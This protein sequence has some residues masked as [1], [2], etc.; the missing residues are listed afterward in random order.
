MKYPALC[1]A[2]LTALLAPGLAMAQAQVQSQIQAPDQPQSQPQPQAPDNEPVIRCLLQQVLSTLTCKPL[3]EYHFV[4]K[5]D[6]V[7]VYNTYF[8]AHFTEFYC[9]I[10]DKDVT[11]TSRAWLGKMASARLDYESVPG[12][13]SAKVNSPP[14][15]CHVSDTVQCCGAQ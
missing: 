15:E 1:L 6:D 12:C 9:Q 5:R 11:I 2:L 3:H 4:G 13:I 7:Y 14:A 10:F 8:G